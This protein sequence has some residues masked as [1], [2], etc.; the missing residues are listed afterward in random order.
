MKLGTIVKT[1]VVAAAIAFPSI[2]SAT[3]TSRVTNG[4][5]TSVRGVMGETKVTF[6]GKTSECTD[7]GRPHAGPIQ[8]WE[9]G[10]MWDS[11]YQDG[12][13]HSCG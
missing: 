10:W 5:I 2:T 11:Y 12:V 6:E 7:S 3:E 4:H 1:A 13:Y 8:D 9:D